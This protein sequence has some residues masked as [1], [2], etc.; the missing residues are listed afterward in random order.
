MTP[1]NSLLAKSINGKPFVIRPTQAWEISL[2]W[3]LSQQ[4]F[5]TRLNNWASRDLEKWYGS[6]LKL[7]L[8][9]LDSVT[10]RKMSSSKAE[11]W[12]RHQMDDAFLDLRLNKRWSKWSC[13]LWRHRNDCWDY[14]HG[15]A[16]FHAR[17]YP[18]F[19]WLSAPVQSGSFS[20]HLLSHGLINSGEIWN[21]IYCKCMYKYNECDNFD[22]LV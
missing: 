7:A 10:L 22:N 21:H 15:G 14:V 8:T 3:T 17:K 13:P 2:R 1:N 6:W 11:P 5:Q 4:I 20:F 16:I 18:H 12:W 19:S 9:V